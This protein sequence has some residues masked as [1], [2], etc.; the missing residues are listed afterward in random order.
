MTTK[1][2][3]RRESTSLKFEQLPDL[4]RH[5]QQG[6]L[7]L[8]TRLSDR[9]ITPVSLT[10]VVDFIARN[11]KAIEKMEKMAKEHLKKLA[12]EHGTKEEGTT[13]IF[14]TFGEYRVELRA[15]NTKLDDEKV[16][17]MLN[18]KGITITKGMDAETTYI[19]NEEKL[20]ILIEQKKITK[21]E[22]EACRHELKYNL[23]SPKKLGEEADAGGS[24]IT[25]RW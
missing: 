1:K 9:A 16:M 24:E 4:E 13:Q 6:I 18:A 10:E 23:Q 21:D 14:A 19:H 12:Q 5:F 8:A 2:L 25:D 20:K 15:Q 7:D 17:K 3:A 22:L 11:K